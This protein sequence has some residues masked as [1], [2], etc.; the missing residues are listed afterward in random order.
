MKVGTVTI[1]YANGESLRLCDAR[2]GEMRFHLV[3]IIST[4]PP[5]GVLYEWYG[6]NSNP[7]VK[8]VQR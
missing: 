2:I 1:H 7:V 3:R 8:V 6:S 4:P 5:R